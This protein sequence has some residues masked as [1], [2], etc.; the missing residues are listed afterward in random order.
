MVGHE[1]VPPSK[2]AHCRPLLAD[3]A[4]DQP[5][6]RNK[7]EGENIL[8]KQLESFSFEA[9]KTFRSQYKK[10]IKKSTKTLLQKSAFLNDTDITNKDAPIGKMIPQNDDLFSFDL[11][12][13]KNPSC[14]ENFNESENERSQLQSI[15]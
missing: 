4:N 14:S 7:D 5:S 9:I 2:K 12:L 6:N 8:N 11:S 13:I 3:F 10:P 1:T 15:Q